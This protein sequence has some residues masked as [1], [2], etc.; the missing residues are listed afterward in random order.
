MDLVSSKLSDPYNMYLSVNIRK[1]FIIQKRETK[2]ND[3]LK[4]TYAKAD[5]FQ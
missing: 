5:S 1:L 3:K 2:Y 4:D